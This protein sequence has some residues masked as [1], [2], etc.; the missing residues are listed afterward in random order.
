MVNFQ[1]SEI[2]NVYVPP[3]T[4]VKEIKKMVDA[5]LTQNNVKRTGFS[6][7]IFQGEYYDEFGGLEN[8]LPLSDYLLKTIELQ[9]LIES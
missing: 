9:V 6:E 3:S 8:D 4:K 5:W 1:K 7:L 2:L